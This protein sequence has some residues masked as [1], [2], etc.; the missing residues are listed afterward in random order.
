[1]I[2]KQVLGS[3]ACRIAESK[4]PK[5]MTFGFLLEAGEAGP[6]QNGD[7]AEGVGVGMN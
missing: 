2:A 4:F 3:G 5:S 7:A 1:M 6:A